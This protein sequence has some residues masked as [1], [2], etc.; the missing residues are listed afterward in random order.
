MNYLYPKQVIYLYR[1]IIQQSGGTVGLR[2]EGLLESAVYRPQASFG[3][4]DLYQDLFS[5]A[6]ALG[7]SL[8]S[9]HPFVDGNKRV[10]FEAMRLMLRLNG[11]DIRASLEAKFDFVMDVAQGK[12][13]EQAIADWLKQHSRPHR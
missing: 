12:R 5:K 4:Q 3:G 6:A 11:Y 2:D 1:Q 10:G 13:T 8:I 7:H 9:N